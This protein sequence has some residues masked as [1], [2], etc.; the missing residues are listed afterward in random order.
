MTVDAMTA[1]TDSSMARGIALTCDWGTLDEY[2]ALLNT[3]AVW[4]MPANDDLGLPGTPA[5]PATPKLLP[6]CA[7]GAVWVCRALVRTRSTSWR[8]AR[9]SSRRTPQHVPG[10]RGCTTDESTVN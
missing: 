5:G 1:R 7:S 10:P 4:E 6:V 8:P 2:L 3:D 9:S